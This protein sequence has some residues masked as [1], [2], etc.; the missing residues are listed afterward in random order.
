MHPSDSCWDLHAESLSTP[1]HYLSEEGISDIYVYDQVHRNPKYL[2]AFLRFIDLW[3]G[4][5]EYRGPVQVVNKEYT[6]A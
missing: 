5:R 3:D 4:V 2:L 6:L 1:V